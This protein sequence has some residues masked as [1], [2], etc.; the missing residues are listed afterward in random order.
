MSMPW[1]TPYEQIRGEEPL[2]LEFV[3]HERSESSCTF[4]DTRRLGC[5]PS[6]FLGWRT[7]S[8][9]IIVG[10]SK[11]VTRK[12]AGVVK[13]LR[14]EPQNGHWGVLWPPHSSDAVG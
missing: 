6:V 4:G 2:L 7:L 9:N 1:K 13:M 11:G 12:E 8:G 3:E 10:T 5:R 14:A